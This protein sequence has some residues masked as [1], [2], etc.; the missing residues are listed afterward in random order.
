MGKIDLPSFCSITCHTFL[1][2]MH[3]YPYIR[4]LSHDFTSLE[5]IVGPFEDGTADEFIANKYV[6]DSKEYIQPDFTS[7]ARIPGE[8]D[9]PEISTYFHEGDPTFASDAKVGW[10]VHKNFCEAQGQRLCSLDELCPI[11]VFQQSTFPD[12]FP[13]STMEQTCLPLFGCSDQ[14]SHSKATSA[15]SRAKNDAWMQSKEAQ[16]IANFPLSYIDPNDMAKVWPLVSVA[17]DGTR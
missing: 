6:L 12:F 8:N 3:Q 17:H 16:N 2:L 10:Y 15:V 9:G 11:R 1:I 7:D 5:D 13:A 4:L 14:F